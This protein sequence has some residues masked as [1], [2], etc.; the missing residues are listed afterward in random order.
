MEIQKH[1]PT[2]LEVA[3]NSQT[4]KDSTPVYVALKVKD[5]INYAAQFTGQMKSMNADDLTIMTK[6]V[7]DY[8]LSSCPT[9]RVDEMKIAIRDGINAQ[10]GEF[11]GL[12]AMTVIN[13]ISAHLK[14]E[15]R[16]NEISRVNAM[17]AVNK[18][19]PTPEEL[20]TSRMNA[21]I[22]DY[23]HFIRTC[24]VSKAGELIEAGEVLDIGNA[25]YTIL[26]NAG[27]IRFEAEQWEAYKQR[28]GQIEFARITAERKKASERIDKI[29]V[30]KADFMLS[31][32]TE[33]G[34]VIERIA[35]K[36]AVKDYFISLRNS[37]LNNK[38]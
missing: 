15:K 12:N 27:L 26:W 37:E 3:L 29:G 1:K 28:A 18:P 25:T 11:R 4:V 9:L 32:L 22:S 31:E 16:A 19:D 21:V 14:Q 30:Q 24:K 5:A 7:A 6:F 20:K 23:N 17:K 2:E 10:Y 13:F 38:M 33:N 35:R 8:I 34:D 36:L